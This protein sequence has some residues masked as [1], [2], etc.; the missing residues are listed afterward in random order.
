MEEHLPHHS[1]KLRIGESPTR[2]S[3]LGSDVQSLLEFHHRHST[4]IMGGGGSIKQAEKAIYSFSLQRIWVI[5]T[6]KKAD[7]PEGNGNSSYG[8]PP[9]VEANLDTC[10]SREMRCS[11]MLQGR[12]DGNFEVHDMETGVE[13]LKGFVEK[14][15]M[16][17][18]GSCHNESESS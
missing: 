16:K 4:I 2:P 12:C 6:G 10:S 1:G 18:D 13:D 5:N 7:G 17:H 14:D 15:R 11:G 9:D 3:S 8:E